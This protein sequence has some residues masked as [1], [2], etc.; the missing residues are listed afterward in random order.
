MK[1]KHLLNYVNGYK[2]MRVINF[3]GIT[4]AEGDSSELCY[5]EVADKEIYLITP[6][7]GLFIVTVK[8]R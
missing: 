4:L 1:L 2:K 3:A 7:E 5:N 6:K 8:S